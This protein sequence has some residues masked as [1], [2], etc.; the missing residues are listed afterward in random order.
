[1]DPPLRLDII[2]YQ[3]KLC[4]NLAIADLRIK[5]AEAR[6]GPLSLEELLVEDTWRQHLGPEFRKPYMAKLQAF[7]HEEWTG[8]TVFPPKHLIFRRAH[9]ASILWKLQHSG[10]LA[11]H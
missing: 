7:L 6:G 11:G 4:R 9:T 10:G 8:H 3:C 1:M 2:W 5:Q